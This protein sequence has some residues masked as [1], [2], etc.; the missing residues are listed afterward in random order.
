MLGVLV[1][2][3][4]A[5]LLTAVFSYDKLIWLAVFL[6]PL[7]IPLH[8][9]VYGLPFDMFIPTEPLLFG[10]L[11][12]FLLSFIRGKRFDK[13]I[14]S[15]PVSVAIYVYLG[16]M[17]LATV[18]SSMPLISVKFLVNRIWYV[19]IFFFLLTY[20]FKSQKNIE[21]FI[22]LFTIAFVP[23]ITYTIIRHL[24]YGLYD[25]QAAHFVM[26]PF[27]NDHTSYG[28]VLAMYIP[29]LIGFSYY[30]RNNLKIRFWT[31]GLT[32]FF[33]LA[34]ILSY[35]R[36]AWLSLFMVGGL[37]VIYR[38]RIKF[39][40]ILITIASIVVFIL[41]FQE[42]ILQK[43]EQNSQDSSANLL[44]H[45]SSMTNITTDASNLERINRWNCAIKLFKERPVFGWGPG[46]YAMKY[47]PYQLTSQRTIISTNSGDGG[48]AHSEYLGALAEEGLLGSLSFIALI[49]VVITVGTRAYSA[50]DDKRLKTLL[51]SAI[52]G[53]ITYYF[54]S[55]LNNF[56]DTDKASV[57][58]WGFTAVIVAIDVYIKKQK[59]A[60]TE[61]QLEQ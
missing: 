37:W 7:S 16:W 45:L 60:P 4:F 14:T 42:P 2:V 49:I 26:S 8:E 51:L 25:D 11:L 48:N 10:I 31:W 13:G 56:L 18:T 36:A 29:F 38:L 9:I 28:A 12:L 47:A 21:K 44:D 3:I 46:T 15:H 5:V 27:F 20:L 19:V 35:T 34:E 32:A 40:T 43:L 58:F 24:G 54:H 33:L 57:P 30:Y 6:T 50:T 39:K 22:W 55:I 61:N 59:N 23:V 17:T 52:L 53:L 41:A 1:P